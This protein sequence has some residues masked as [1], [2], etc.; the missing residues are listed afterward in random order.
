MIW[1]VLIVYNYT[2]K[3]NYQIRKINSKRLLNDSE[4]SISIKFTLK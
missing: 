2:F 1:H 4:K 3:K